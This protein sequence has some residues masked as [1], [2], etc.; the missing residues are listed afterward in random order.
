MDGLK[1]L[2]DVREAIAND[3]RP[4]SADP[5]HYDK[6]LKLSAT[7]APAADAK[8]QFSWA[9]F[10]WA[11]DPYVIIVTIYI[12]S[13]Y[14]SNVVVGDPIRGQAIWGN[15]NSIAGFIIALFGPILGAIA[16]T[17]G[18]RK[19][20]LIAFVAVMVP[21]IFALWW[22]LP[23]GA[24]L[25]IYQIALLFIVVSVAFSFTEVFHNSMLPAVAPHE[26]IGFLSGLALAMA[27]A[28][29]LLILCFMLFA[30]M[31]PGQ[32]DWS[33]LP[34]KAL[35]GLD[36]SMHEN[37]R[38]SGPITAIWLLV[39]T[40]PLLFFT[41]DVKPTQK[42]NKV[43]AV[44]DG[45]G[46]VIKTVKQV[47]HYRNVTTYLI[48]R[49]FFNDGQTAVLIFGGV[50]AAGVFKWDALT[51]TIYGIILSI[52][53]VGG[54]FFGGWLDDR[55]GSKK[56]I[57]TSIGGTS[58]GIVLAVSMTP[59]EM[60]FFIPYDTTGPHLW[61]LPFFSTLPELMYLIVVLVVAICITA[62]YANSRTM[63]ARIAPASK[64]SEFFGLYALSGTATAFMG[65]LLVGLATTFFQSQRMGF[66]SILILMVVGLAIMAFVDETRVEAAD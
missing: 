27:N 1:E 18:R 49:M 63:L 6:G 47:R 31:L 59:T 16:D 19:P 41:P 34:T 25:G 21:A 30:F 58:I 54:G 45:I 44:K 11:R 50:Y 8:G 12:F 3:P 13:P 14:F 53:A 23:G 36:V 43:K 4:D 33:F 17:G 10:Q 46:R 37:S 55:F 32:V 2:G 65:P 40:L 9:M 62:A 26:R 38:I 56:A 24:G 42:I 64:M 22:A 52:F 15:I 5:A 39:F 66:A 60:F 29:A 51:L 48:A 20:W 61:S 28:G 35:F 57:M 7:G